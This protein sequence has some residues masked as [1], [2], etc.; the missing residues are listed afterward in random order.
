ML[1]AILNLIENLTQ[2]KISVMSPFQIL[3][4]DRWY[5]R[6]ESNLLTKIVDFLPILETKEKSILTAQ[7]SLLI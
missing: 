7:E 2:K 1:E 6:R 3:Y 5:Y 4:G